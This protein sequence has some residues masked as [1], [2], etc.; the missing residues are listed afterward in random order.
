[1][2]LLGKL[3]GTAIPFDQPTVMSAWAMMIMAVMFVLA[4]IEG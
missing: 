4:W 3:S 2:S 1:M